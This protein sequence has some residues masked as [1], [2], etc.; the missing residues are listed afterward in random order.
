MSKIMSAREAINLFIQDGMTLGF[1]GFLASVHAEEV[2]AGI[3]Q[4]FLETGH[5]RDLT[6]LYA[7]GQGDGAQ[8]GLNHLGEEGLLRRVIGGHWGQI[9]R[10]HV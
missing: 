10:A 7:A 9:G 3:G 5:P 2:T 4:S 8:L 1:S 6:A